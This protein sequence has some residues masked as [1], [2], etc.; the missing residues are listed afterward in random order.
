M[1]Q[2]NQKGGTQ[3]NTQRL[4]LKALSPQTLEVI[5]E[6]KKSTS[7]D[8]ATVLINRFM[9]TEPNLKGQDTIRRRIYDV[10]NVLSAARLIDKVGKQIIWNGNNPYIP[11][12]I[13]IAPNMPP[14]EKDLE[15]K[16]K[17]LS[18][19]IRLLT[20]YKLLIQRNFNRTPPPNAIHFPT[21]I[22]GIRDSNQ[23]ALTHTFNHSE[24]EIRSKMPLIF[25]SPSD[26]LKK[27]R[28]PKDKI[29]QLLSLSPELYKY[30]AKLLIDESN[31]ECAN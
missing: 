19:K 30:G 2:T 27:L 3:S 12:P 26:I 1:I 7:E 15:E 18:E 11:T 25:L 13:P 10:I 28:F 22:I 8:I 4:S 14:G 21:I 20:Y 31:S 6:L 16:E 17:T 9:G 24:L 29:R 5:Q 23:A